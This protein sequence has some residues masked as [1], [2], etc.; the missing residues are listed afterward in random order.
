M[1]LA[2]KL[3]HFVCLSACLFAVLNAFGPG[4]LFVCSCH[5]F[6]YLLIFLF[7]SLVRLFVPI[8]LSMKLFVYFVPFVSSCLFALFF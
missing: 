6:F 8:C 5:C 2:V 4:N 1:Y 3:R 7:V